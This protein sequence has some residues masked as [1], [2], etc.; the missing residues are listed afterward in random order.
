[1]VQGFKVILEGALPCLALAVMVGGVALM[2][3]LALALDGDLH[4]LPF[5]QDNIFFGS[6]LAGGIVPGSSGL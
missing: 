6:N 5:P 3:A 2:V 1:M 4:A